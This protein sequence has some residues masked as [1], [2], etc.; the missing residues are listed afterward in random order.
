MS[1]NVCFLISALD[2]SGGTERVTT[3]IANS[4]TE[5]GFNVS[6]MSSIGGLSPFFKLDDSIKVIS[7]YPEHVSIK[8][9]ALGLILRIRK[10][11]LRE[12][13]ETLIV[14]DSINCVF[15]TIAS[16]GL[17]IN[18]ICW[19]HFNL[20]VNLGSLF[21]SLGRRLAVQWCDHIVTLTQ[22]DKLNWC[23]T[24]KIKDKIHSIN[25]PSTCQR[26][27]HTPSLEMKTILCVGRLTEQKGFDLLIHS[28]AKIA[29]EFNSWKII[30]VGSGNDEPQLKDMINKY[31]LAKSIIL[32]GQQS[33]VEPFY[34]SAS[35]FCMSSRFEGLPMVLLE[36]QSYSLP[37]VAFDCDT[38]P[39]EII[40][41]NIS[42]FIVEHL[43]IDDLAKAL[44]K[45]MSID[46]LN[47]DRMSQN[48][49]KNTMH[50]DLD[51]T[52]LRW[53]EII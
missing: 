21:R 49:L 46:Q 41:D 33:D 16:A 11:L 17:N 4:L 8:K 42:G 36:A 3:L 34:R 6:I 43:N 20:N 2:H 40:Q 24:F 22:R 25:N 39:A 35:F 45:M 47:Y 48:A 44:R 51:R 5:R 27:T 1:K 10:V 18:H 7:L 19:E 31:G 38:G 9:N 12:K 30:I 23:D 15:S 32:K 26:Q 52:I 28:W 13:I 14:V 29:D 53:E 37:I 50:F